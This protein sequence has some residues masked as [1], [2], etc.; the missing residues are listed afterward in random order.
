MNEWISFQI[1]D[2]IL[3]SFV[4]FFWDF[5]EGNSKKEDLQMVVLKSAKKN[6]GKSP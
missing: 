5:N 2:F 1:F 3:R 6:D 4:S